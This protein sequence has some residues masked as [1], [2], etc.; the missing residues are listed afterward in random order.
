MKPNRA[1]MS[2]SL[3]EEL[4]FLKCKDCSMLNVDTHTLWLL[5]QVNAVS[6]DQIRHIILNILLVLIL[7]NFYSCLIHLT[8]LVSVSVSQFLVSV[9]VSVSLT[10]LLKWKHT[11]AS[12]DFDKYFYTTIYCYSIFPLNSL[13]IHSTL[14]TSWWVS[15]DV[16]NFQHSEDPTAHHGLGGS[17]NLLYKP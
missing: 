1:R 17:P 15:A 7:P 2:D 9:S 5:V 12:S 11:E 4:V 16:I 10:S 13:N 6:V 3:H 14:V 8:G